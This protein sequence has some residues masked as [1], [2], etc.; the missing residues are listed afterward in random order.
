MRGYK[1]VFDL[2]NK[3]LYTE[4]MFPPG[5][6]ELDAAVGATFSLDLFMLLAI[7]ISLQFSRD[8]N[9]GIGK[10]RND[11]LVALREMSGKF[12]IFCNRGRIHAPERYSRLFFYLEPCIKQAHIPGGSFH[13][14]FWLL[15]YVNRIDGQII[16]RIFVLSRNLTDSHDL[17]VCYFADGKVDRRLNKN[18]GLKNAV[19]F[20]SDTD[21]D[22]GTFYKQFLDDIPNIAFELPRGIDDIQF[23]DVHETMFPDAMAESLIVISPFLKETKLKEL[24]AK[25]E[26][27]RWLF[28]LRESLNEINTK[29]LEK[30]QVYVLNDEFIDGE[31]L[32]D[33]QNEPMARKTL[34]LHAKIYGMSFADGSNSIYLGSANCTN[35]AF[36]RNKE[37]TV[38]LISSSQ[39]FSPKIIHESLQKSGIFEEYQSLETGKVQ[40]DPDNSIVRKITRELEA[41]KITGKAER[42]ANDEFL[43]RINIE[44]KISKHKGWYLK[45]A[46]MTRKD[47]EVALTAGH[48]VFGPILMQD[49]SRF[50]ILSIYKG[51]VKK[52]LLVVMADI[53]MPDER[54]KAVFNSLIDSADKLLNYLELYIDGKTPPEESS[55]GGAHVTKDHDPVIGHYLELGFTGN[56]YENLLIVASREPEKLKRIGRVIEDVDTNQKI[57]A[58]LLADLKELWKPF[59]PFIR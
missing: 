18:A 23:H 39:R 2:K 42:V 33:E 7:P 3:H 29:T 4:Q 50:I 27:K 21:E 49:L 44:G 10:D 31:S 14:K 12:R 45:A 9:D 38:E 35:A 56:L 43:I 8:L 55:L 20:L 5:G 52:D 48:I 37:F 28:S 22:K 19:K 51:A 13:P 46:M 24:A 25:T 36:A 26:K 17:D 16:Y 30:Y 1:N 40:P 34:N 6:Y 47:Q 11:V 32:L 59:Q 15:R 58:R 54:G 57:D 53:D 41:L